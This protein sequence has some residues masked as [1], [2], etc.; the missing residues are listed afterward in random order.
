MA[1]LT[2]Y[3]TSRTGH[4]ATVFGATGFMGRY[5]V[6]NLAK[7]GTQVV[8]PFRGNEDDSRYLRPMGDLGQIVKLHFDLR[9][10]EQL[11]ANLRHSDVVYNLIGREWETKNFSWDQ[12]HVEGAR[13]LARLAREQGVSKFVHVSALNAHVD[14]PSAFLRS[15]ARGEVAVLEEFPGAIIV[16]PG[17][18]YGHEDRFWNVFGYYSKW[19]PVGFPIINGEQKLRPVYV[20]DVAAALAML[21]KDEQAYGRTFELVGPKEYYYKSLVD[22]WLWH[23]NRISN[24]L[25]LPKP[26]AALAVKA[27]S[28][29]LANPLVVP[30][31][32]ERAFIN[33]AH[34]PG[35]E[36]FDYFH[37]KPH[38]IEDTIMLFSRMYR[39]FETHRYPFEPSKL[40]YTTAAADRSSV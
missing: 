34:T 6:N 14:S 17:T 27:W 10:E 16:R 29:F 33:D 32:V 18:M 38:T 28:T 20:A 11:I 9:N 22:F 4:V 13:K 21:L 2:F 19:S 3:P 8:I 37:I 7:K 39:H 35:V 36:G 5:L 23:T 15:K 1:R 30:D 24:K 31:D 25:P 40:D 26:V 12:V